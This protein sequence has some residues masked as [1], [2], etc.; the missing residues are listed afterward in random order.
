MSDHVTNHV[1]EWDVPSKLGVVAKP[2][3]KAHRFSTKCALLF[4]S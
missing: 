1:M 2:N 3:P 4:S